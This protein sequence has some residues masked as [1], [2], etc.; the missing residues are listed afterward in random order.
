MKPWS[1]PWCRCHWGTLSQVS[2]IGLGL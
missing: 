2:S 1:K